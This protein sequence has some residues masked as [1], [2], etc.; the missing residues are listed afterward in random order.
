MFTLE[1]ILG[2]V[3]TL[4]DAPGDDTPRER[5]RA[6][7]RESLGSI[8][9]VRDFMEACL[10]NKGPQYDRALQDLV[11]H[12]ASL[13]GFSVEF[14]RYRGVSND[15]GYD[16]LWHWNDFTF[17]VEVKTTDAY[18][19]QTA[20]VIGYVDKLISAGRIS[21]WDHSLGLY[22]FGRTDSDLKQLANTIHAEKRTHQLRITTTESLLSLVELVQDSQISPEE[23]ATLLRP[24]GVFVADTVRLLARIASRAA[25]EV[26]FSP[27]LFAPHAPDPVLETE[28]G[29]E[30]ASMRA[31]A[32]DSHA[33]PSNG[34]RVHLLT[35]VS[36]DEGATAKDTIFNLLR[37]GWYVFGDRTPGRKVL[38][39]GDRICFYQSSVGVVAEA[40]VASIPEQ[41]VPPV[42][43][44]VKNL[45]RFPWAFEVRNPRF[46]FD[47]PVVLDADLR[48]RLEAFS[49]RD[50]SR[51]WAW[52]VQGT[53]QVSEHDYRLLTQSVGSP[54]R[55]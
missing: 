44:L 10:R 15:I 19:I 41:R 47:E 26:P 12:A 52:F 28:S 24:G 53:H 35:P 22:I 1:Q 7:L 31:S 30:S 50:P 20:P 27:E 18:S 45:D 51:P 54:V 38:K 55:R 48:V 5:F 37:S 36:D 2:L 32:T 42:K 6:F 13:L 34:E 25:T 16:G 29:T 11:N 17:V 39:P 9:A 40:E 3:G 8:G 46:F 43:G 33:Q 14:G 49:G 23:A 21:D 4:D